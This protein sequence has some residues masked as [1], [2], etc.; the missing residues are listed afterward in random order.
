LR[1]KGLLNAH[2]CT[3]QFDTATREALRA[4]Q[5]REGL[6]TTGLVSYETVEHLGLKLD[7]IFRSRAHTEAPP[8]GAASAR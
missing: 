6:P 4:F 5:K 3:G 8:P 1:G 7:A 2:E